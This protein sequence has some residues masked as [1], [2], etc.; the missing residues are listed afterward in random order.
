MSHYEFVEDVFDTTGRPPTGWMH[1]IFGDGPFG[2]DV[3]RRIPGPPPADPLLIEARDEW[4]A[5]H[6]RLLNVISW[7]DPDDRIALYAAELPEG[8]ESGWYADRMQNDDNP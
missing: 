3:G 8:N 1:A 5:W 2:H 6:Y 4:P 7:S